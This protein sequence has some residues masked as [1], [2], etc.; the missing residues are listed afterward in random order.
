MNVAESGVP[1]RR[2]K[3]AKWCRRGDQNEKWND[4]T[5]HFAFLI[6]H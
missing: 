2:M 5:L 3:N 4:E 1:Q 6:L